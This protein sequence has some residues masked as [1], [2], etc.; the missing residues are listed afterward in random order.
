MKKIYFLVLSIALTGIVKAQTLID[1]PSDRYRLSSEEVYNLKQHSQGPIN[2]AQSFYM[3][4]SAANFDDDFFVWRMN[5]NYTG[6]DTALNFIGLSLN[7]I[8]GFTDAADPAGTICDSSLFG[9]TSSYPTDIGIRVDTIF[10]IVSHENNSGNYDKITMQIVELLTTPQAQV[11]FPASASAG[12]S[13]VL[14][15]QIDSSNVSLSTNG[16]WLG[17]GAA[18]VLSYTPFPTFLG[19]NAPK[20][21]GLVFKYNDP[22]K[23]DTFSMSA[24]Y[25]KDPLDNTKGLQSSIKSSFMRYPPFISTIS[26]NSTIGYGTFANGVFSGG[27]YKAQNWAMWAYVTVGT[28]IDGFGENAANGFRILEAYPNPTNNNTN[29]RYELGV[30]SDVSVVVTDIV[31]NVVSQT[32]NAQQTPGE[33]KVSLGTENLSN[34]IY[35]YTVNANKASISKRFIVQH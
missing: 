11:G 5:S 27:Y 23:L 8:A 29:V 22:S 31:G 17:T 18:V 20:K 9:F 32:T 26:R 14:W 35:T 33:Y 6:A 10:A 7:H 28:D 4:H 34:G 13:T 16:N 2:R 15:E 24:G 25:V 3:D 1:K 12:V 19:Y 30:T 21:I